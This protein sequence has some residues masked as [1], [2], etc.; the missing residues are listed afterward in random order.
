MT[1][2]QQQRERAERRRKLEEFWRWVIGEKPDIG[3]F[4]DC[5]HNLPIMCQQAIELEWQCLETADRQHV[6]DDELRRDI[7][8]AQL[9][10]LEMLEERVSEVSHDEPTEK[11]LDSSAPA[12]PVGETHAS[13]QAA[14]LPLK[15]NRQGKFGPIWQK[16]D[17]ASE[18]VR[19]GVR[20]LGL[21]SAD[22][23]GTLHPWEFK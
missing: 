7:S 6:E 20:A 4:I 3:E 14:L 5:I 17:D 10:V 8:L 19:E 16:V 21:G 12:W 2:K 9:E 18:W 11:Q 23:D 13:D 15:P 1:T 22:S